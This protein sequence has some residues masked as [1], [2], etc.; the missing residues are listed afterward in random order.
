VIDKAALWVPGEDP[1]PA[2]DDR[3]NR[4]LDLE[5]Q[6]VAVVLV[7]F[8]KDFCGPSLADAAAAGTVGNAQTALRANAFAAEAAEFGVRTIYSRQILDPSRLT[9][10]Q[11]RWEHASPLCLAGSEG[12]ELFL[13]PV[14]GARVV[15]KDRFDVWQSEEFQAV[16]EEWAIDGLVI[17]GV[18]LQCCLLYAVL[19]AEERGFHYVVP[20]DLVSGLDRCE[21][22][23]NRAVREY[24]GYV[25]PAPDS[26]QRLLEGWRRR[27]TISNPPGTR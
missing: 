1:E 12:A 24:L 23:S 20:G 26:A 6:G 25:H 4:L 18:E 3:I 16:L 5:P 2:H 19:G 27:M 14:P 15:R 7:D 10:R 13:S 17:G 11:R 21:P 9:P 22:T 8:Q